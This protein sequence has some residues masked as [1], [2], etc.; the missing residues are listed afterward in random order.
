MSTPN[1]YR[2][3]IV[4]VQAGSKAEAAD[5]VGGDTLGV[6]DGLVDGEVTGKIGFMDTLEAAEEGAECC[7]RALAGSAVNLPLAVT[8]I[9]ARPFLG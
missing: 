4:S 2:S 7:M 1:I 5:D 9:V 3:S 6:A 8:V